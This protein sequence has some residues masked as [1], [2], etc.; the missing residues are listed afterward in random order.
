VAGDV[1]RSTVATLDYLDVGSFG[2]DSDQ[3]PVGPGI[4]GFGWW[5][6]SFVG[7]TSTRT[8]P[9]APID[10]FQ[11][12]GHFE[13]E[14]MTIIPSLDIVVAARGNWGQFDPGN[15]NATMNQNLRLLVSAVEK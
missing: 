7:L 2:G 5:F 15:P 12:N 11:A 4:Y 6:N 14:I 10:T 8:W 1:P 3:T 9:D 13:H